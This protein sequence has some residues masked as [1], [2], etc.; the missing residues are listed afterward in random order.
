MREYGKDFW[1]DYA[2]TPPAHDAALPRPTPERPIPGSAEDGPP[3]GTRSAP[4]TS[5]AARAEPFAPHCPTRPRLLPVA[6]QPPLI[7]YI[8]K[9][10][11]GAGQETTSTSKPGEK[12]G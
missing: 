10:H 1:D 12:R 4:W 5:P 3:S 8:E 2:A 9:S 6:G 7:G 11:Q